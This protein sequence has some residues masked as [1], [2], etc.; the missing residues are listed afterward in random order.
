MGCDLLVDSLEKVG[1]DTIFA[2]PGG[3]SMMLHQSLTRSKQIRTILPRH[4]QGGVFMAE[5]YARATGKPGVVM[6]TSGPG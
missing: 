2:Y 1:V 3:A 4:E 5:G 6:A